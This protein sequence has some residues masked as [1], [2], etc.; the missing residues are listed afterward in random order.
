MFLARYPTLEPAHISYYYCHHLKFL[1]ASVSFATY[2]ARLTHRVQSVFAGESRSRGAL[3]V[4][5]AG[6]PQDGRLR[7]QRG[8]HVGV[9]VGRR[10]PV[11]EVS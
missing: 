7:D 2:A 8:H 11:L 10:P 9:H 4:G 5:V 3:A 1:T 6:L